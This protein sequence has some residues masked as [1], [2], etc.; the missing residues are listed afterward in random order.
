MRE[1]HSARKRIGVILLGSHGIVTEN[2]PSAKKPFVSLECQMA[3]LRV[4]RA[5]ARASQTKIARAS[6]DRDNESQPDRDNE[7]QPAR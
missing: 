2:V 6:Q 1:S 7:S 3:S 4:Q 5:L